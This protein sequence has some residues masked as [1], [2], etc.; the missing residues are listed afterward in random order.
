MRF[1]HLTKTC[2]IVSV[3]GLGDTDTWS[4]ESLRGLG[5][6]K[7]FCGVEAVSSLAN[8]NIPPTRKHGVGLIDGVRS[9]N[10][11]R[12]LGGSV[13]PGIGEIYGGYPN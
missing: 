2:V 4:R 8:C 13:G 7:G 9:R 12:C 6:Q 5:S 1:P 11:S 10:L 3:F